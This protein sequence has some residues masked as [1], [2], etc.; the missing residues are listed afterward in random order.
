MY[1]NPFW[2]GFLVGFVAAIVLVL[3]VGGIAEG[4][5]K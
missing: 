3:V 5:K 1:I 2:F 4:G